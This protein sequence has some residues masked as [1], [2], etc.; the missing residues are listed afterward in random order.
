MEATIIPRRFSNETLDIFCNY[1]LDEYNAIVKYFD[2]KE[3]V[4]KVNLDSM[5]IIMAK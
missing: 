1:F 2:S 5:I 3:D 4:E